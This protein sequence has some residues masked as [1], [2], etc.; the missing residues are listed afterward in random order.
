MGI[1]EFTLDLLQRVFER[2]GIR[3]A[4]KVL[5]FA[6][7]CTGGSYSDTRVGFE[8]NYIMDS[9][10]LKLIKYNFE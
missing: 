3:V 4:L 8:D 9:S 10:A 2:S 5:L 6:C 1:P 7:I